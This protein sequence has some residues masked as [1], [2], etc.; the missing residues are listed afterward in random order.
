M[1][2]GDGVLPY[3][4]CGCNTT[5]ENYSIFFLIHVFQ[6][7][8][9][10]KLAVKLFSSIILQLLVE[11]PANTGWPNGHKSLCM[12]ISLSSWLLRPHIITVWVFLIVKVWLLRL[13]NLLPG[14]M[15]DK[16]STRGV[17]IGSTGSTNRGSPLLGGTGG[18]A[19]PTW[20]GSP[21]KQTHPAGSSS[22]LFFIRTCGCFQL[23][24]KM[25]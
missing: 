10:S 8:S 13:A 18:S 2:Y 22:E 17:N 20:Q 4:N 3:G 6:L 21:E 19:K 5:G 9:A 24:L 7:T 16:T 25:K 12:R 23:K 14:N 1:W 11:L 15:Q